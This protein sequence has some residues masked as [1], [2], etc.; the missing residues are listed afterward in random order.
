MTNPMPDQFPIVRVGFDSMSAE[1][2][3]ETTLRGVAEHLG[4]I[5]ERISLAHL[6]NIAADTARYFAL[7]D[8]HRQVGRVR[9]QIGVK[10][11]LRTGM[12]G[13]HQPDKAVAKGP[14]AEAQYVDTLKFVSKL[15]P[16][17]RPLDQV[18]ELYWTIEDEQL[19]FAHQCAQEVI[20]RF[21]G[22]S[23]F[24]SENHTYPEDILESYFRKL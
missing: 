18:N 2:Q 24:M 15:S 21:P 3:A 5:E 16:D 13:D 17:K 20:G 19:R 12:I 9:R 11:L 8:L 6:T 23:K 1:K 14:E 4:S 22:F 7:G 10:T